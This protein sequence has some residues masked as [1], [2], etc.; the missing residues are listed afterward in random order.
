V[1][2]RWD[3]CPAA[4]ILAARADSGDNSGDGEGKG[5]DGRAAGGGELGFARAAS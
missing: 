1:E 4:A 5:A 3:E 2:E